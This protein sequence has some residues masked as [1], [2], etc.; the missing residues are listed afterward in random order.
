MA[1][2]SRLVYTQR[3]PKRPLTESVSVHK[4]MG[5]NFLPDA[6]RLLHT[7]APWSVPHRLETGFVE[8]DEVSS[9][10]DPMVCGFS[11]DLSS[12]TTQIAKLIVHGQDRSQALGLLR[13][14]LA[15][16]QVIGPS[17]NIEFL[18]TV[19]AH[20]D[21]A[22]GPVETSF[23]PTHHDE[24]F[25]TSSIPAEVLVQAGLYLTLKPTLA[26]AAVGA[27]SALPYR[28]FGDTASRKFAFDGDHSVE[29][30]IGEDGCQVTTGDLSVPARAHFLS[31]TELVSQLP[32]ARFQSTLLSVGNKLHVYHAG[33]HYTLT[34]PL[35]AEEQQAAQQTTDVLKAPMPAAVIEVRVS[36]GQEVQNGQVSSKALCT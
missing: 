8:G 10:Y 5:R 21:F 30:R 15:Q 2:L 11:S 18:K 20:P 13:A 6:G 16:Y 1:T 23:I 28:R 19:A 3:D 22:A 25:P 26:E 31:P 17:T 14:A 4:L 9:Y 35:E 34:L 33:Q 32:E 27:W 36:Q 12:L 7:Q 29:V 24:L